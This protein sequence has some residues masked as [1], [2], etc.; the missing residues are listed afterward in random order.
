MVAKKLRPFGVSILY[1]D[2]IRASQEAEA[3]Y[4]AEF[5]ALEELLKR[6]DIVTLHCPY[7]QDYHHMMNERTFA[8]MKPSAYFINCARGRLVDERALVNA[9]SNNVIAGAGIDVYEDEPFPLPE[10]LALDN[11]SVSPHIGTFAYEARVE[12]TREC[13][14][15][16]TAL[17][18]GE[19]PSN[20]INPQVLTKK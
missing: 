12:M 6:A 5:V 19:K 3:E 13:L 20:V 1:Y 8:L 4:G 2:V 9:L 10:L 17:L 7:T 18:R 16:I 11:V 14:G 15:G